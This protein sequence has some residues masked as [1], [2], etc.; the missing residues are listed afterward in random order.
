METFTLSLKISY[1][2]LKKKKKKKK[3]EGNLKSPKVKNFFLEIWGLLSELSSLKSS[4]S[5]EFSLSG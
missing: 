3:S 4:E 2:F 5:S 1:I